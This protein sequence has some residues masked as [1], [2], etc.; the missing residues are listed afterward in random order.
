MPVTVSQLAIVPVKGMRLQ[1]VSEV[2]LG[3]HGITGDREFLVI[4]EDGKLLLT[5]QTPALLQIDPAWDPVRNVL[6]LVFPDGKV[7]ED[8][9]EPG[10][11]AVTRMYDGREM[12]GWI[13]P[14]PLGA[15]LSGYLGRRVHLFRCAPAHLGADDQPVTL[16]SEASLHALAA[17][18]NGTVPDGRRFRMTI[19]VAGTDAWAEHAWRGQRVTV[20]EVSVRVIAPVP[21][22]VVTTRNP[23]SGAVDARILH[24]LAR[25]RGKDDITFGVWCDIL[26]PGRIHVGDAV[27][28]RPQSSPLPRRQRHE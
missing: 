2:D 28:P 9:P 8:T 6:T 14:G 5:G 20:G 25:L 11:P 12:P 4:G 15:A 24:A 3:R 18:F 21:R 22:C 27:T 23:E 7:V 16:M 1:C 10:A 26:R 19:T 17:A 13:V